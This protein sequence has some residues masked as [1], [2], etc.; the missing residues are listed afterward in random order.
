MWTES[1]K[2]RKVW[3]LINQVLPQCLCSY[4]LWSTSQIIKS[5]DISKSID[6]NQLISINQFYPMKASNFIQSLF[7]RNPTGNWFTNKIV[8]QYK[9]KCY[10][11]INFVHTENTTTILFL[12]SKSVCLFDMNPAKVCLFKVNNK[13]KVWNMFTVNNKD[14]RKTPFTSL[15]CLHSSAVFTPYSCALVANFE[16]VI[17][18]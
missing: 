15:W 1:H 18:C 10:L 16:Q 8:M 12:S 14:T 6:I 17:V 4:G 3:I 5:I 13:N 2:I 9:F 7:S 11:L